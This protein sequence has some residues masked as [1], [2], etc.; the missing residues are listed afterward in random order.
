MWAEAIG[1]EGSG[2]WRASAGGQ[3][4]I[5]IRVVCAMLSTLFSLF[6]FIRLLFRRATPKARLLYFK[7]DRRG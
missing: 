6:L 3:K 1:R 5:A 7:S 2:A 4:M